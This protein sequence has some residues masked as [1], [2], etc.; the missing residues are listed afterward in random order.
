MIKYSGD[1]KR[2]FRK[3][4][5]IDNNMLKFI[6]YLES[7]TV[8]SHNLMC[9]GVVNYKVINLMCKGVVNY[10]VINLMY[11]GV[12]NHKIIDPMWNPM[13]PKRV[14]QELAGSTGYF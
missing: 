13:G 5:H 10:K 11:K 9:K 7:D 4:R 8:Y 2:I 12:V 6:L 3:P 1:V 14:H